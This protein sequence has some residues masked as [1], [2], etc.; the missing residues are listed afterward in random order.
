MCSGFKP[1]KVLMGVPAWTAPWG[2]GGKGS[3]I[4]DHLDEVAALKSGIT[5]WDLLDT[6]DSQWTSADTFVLLKVFK[7][8][9]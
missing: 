9:K 6:I 2:D 8:K 7:E 1:A 3:S 5:I 4:E